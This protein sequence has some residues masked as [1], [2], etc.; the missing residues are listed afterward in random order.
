MGKALLEST[1][2]SRGIKGLVLLTCGSALTNDLHF[3]DL[4]EMVTE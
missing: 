1:K 3:N 2:Q 4:K